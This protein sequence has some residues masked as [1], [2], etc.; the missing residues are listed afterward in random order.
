MRHAAHFRAD[1]EGVDAAGLF[2][3][4]RV[5]EEHPPVAPLVR[6]RIGD[7]ATGNG[8]VVAPAGADESLH[9]GTG[10]EGLVGRA[11]L[12]RRRM[13]GDAAAP[14]IGRLLAAAIG[15]RQAACGL[16]VH[17][18]EGI[19]DDAEPA[20]L[21]VANRRLHGLVGGRA[22]IGRAAVDARD[23]MGVGA[24]E[25]G[26]APGGARH[27]AIAILHAG[28]QVADAAAQIV[29]EPGNDEGD[30][31]KVRAELLQL[32]DRGQPVGLGK[33]GVAVV[34]DGLAV[35][36]AARHQPVVIAELGGGRDHGHRLHH[37]FQPVDDVDDL[38]GELRQAVAEG[39]QGH[40]LEHHIGGVAIARHGA[41]ALDLLDQ[42]IGGRARPAL[43]DAE[44]VERLV[45]R[46]AV[47][48]DPARCG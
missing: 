9:L 4:M 12:A 21:Q 5:V 46:L 10:G 45:E 27:L 39:L 15:V 31:L 16:N 32:V 47:G 42:R 8:E 26:D 29:A 18:D 14:G 28:L 44:I 2:A 20:A 30:A 43:V 17:Q 22:A 40:A 23:Q 36:A 37:L 3:Q 13:A 1:Q 33:A 41:R 7:L 48:P 11:A 19:K 34:A 24:A 6:P 25:G 38:E 35:G